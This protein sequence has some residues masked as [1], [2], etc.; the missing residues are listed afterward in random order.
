MQIPDLIEIFFFMFLILF[1]YFAI[2]IFSCGISDVVYLP[3][4]TQYS[5]IYCLCVICI[6]QVTEVGSPAVIDMDAY[7]AVST[8]H[9]IFSTRRVFTAVT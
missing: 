2:N 1:L 4:P 5:R 8:T 9:I 6:L 3:C 7:V